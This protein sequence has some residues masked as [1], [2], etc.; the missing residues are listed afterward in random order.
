[1]NFLRKLLYPISIIY[2]LITSIRNWLFD[3]GIIKSYTYQIPVIVVGNLSVGG[4]GKTP[5]IEYLIR[6][7]SYNYQVAVLSRG[8][9]RQSKG[10]V[11][12]NKNSNAKML[13]DE[14]FQYFEKFKN[15]II[16]VDSDR[17]N[18]INKLLALDN[19]PNLI[20]LDDA[21]QHRKV[22]ADFKILLTCYGDLYANDIVL[23]AGNLRENRL[24]ANRA[25]LII[26]TKC[27]KN[28]SEIEQTKIKNKL[29]I[30]PNQQLFF[31]FIDY[32]DCVYNNSD[33]I[34]LNEIKTQQK[35]IVVGIAKPKPFVEHIQSN[36]D[37]IMIY[38]DH[39][40]FSDNEIKNI[41]TKSIGKKIITTEKDYVR[42]KNS[43]L[44]QQLFYLPIQTKFVS[45]QVVFDTIIFDFIKNFEPLEKD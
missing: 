40:E 45:N 7:L 25:N 9:K 33:S 17:N 43:E 28:I 11:L 15:T 1:M 41:E 36:K 22:N 3:I 23:P 39:H 37:L 14:P 16:A 8:Y 12:A 38:P 6:L 31:S 30:K 29:K 26:V 24:V 44:K 4:T 2:N 42:L 34:K 21:L 32:D 35:T 5:Q 27:P 13:G 20:L 18:G 10:F 19:K